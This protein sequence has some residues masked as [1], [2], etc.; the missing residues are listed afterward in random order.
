MEKI[1]KV[2]IIGFSHLHIVE[3]VQYFLK[4]RHRFQWIGGGLTVAPDPPG[5]N[6]PFLHS[7][8]L[9]A[10][11]D[12]GVIP[13]LWEDY[14]ELLD[15]K[16]DLILLGCGN[17]QHREVVCEI[18]SRGIHVLVDK[19]LAYTLADAKAMEEAS[20]HGGG[21]VIT[22]WPSAWKPSFHLGRQLVREGTIGDVF[23]FSFHNPDSMLTF[24]QDP[25]RMAQEWWFQ[26]SQGGGSLI[27]YCG[28]GCNL[29]LEFLEQMPDTVFA[30]SQNVCHPFCNVEDY[31]VLTLKNSRSI[32]II[33][34]SWANLC[35]GSPTGP[36]LWGTKGA[37]A[38]EYARSHFEV[39]V[40]T[41]PY[42]IRPTQVHRPDTSVLPAGR[43][44]IEEEVL[45]FLDTGAPVLPALSLKRNLEIAAILEAAGKSVRS[46]KAEAV[47]K[48]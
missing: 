14:R 26:P 32:G 35:S 15:Q 27:D 22:N 36:I 25:A 37:I 7:G 17:G 13:T 20:L 23:R 30:Q 47:E 8:N 24:S 44:S 41:E 11:R 18:V 5:E 4:Q 21:A 2:G 16:P 6:I 34:G 40:F 39:Q 45:R 48:I 12:L 42:N 3:H 38:M 43:T 31:A 1:Y 46:G 9:R 33:E 28:Y 10:C 19:P 29:W